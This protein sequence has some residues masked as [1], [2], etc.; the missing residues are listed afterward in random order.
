V[1]LNT[2]HTQGCVLQLHEKKGKAYKV[3][4]QC[5]DAGLGQAPVV[6]EDIRSKRK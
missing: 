2:A 1:G 3:A 6:N 5:I 4:Q